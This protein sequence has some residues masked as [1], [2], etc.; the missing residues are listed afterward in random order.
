MAITSGCPLNS[1][2]FV[3]YLNIKFKNKNW[4]NDKFK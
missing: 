4:W 2:S 1:S 3:V